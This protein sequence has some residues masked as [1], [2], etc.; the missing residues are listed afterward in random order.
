M[1][2]AL[3]EYKSKS[4]T[5]GKPVKAN[6]KSKVNSSN[7]NSKSIKTVNKKAAGSAAKSTKKVTINKTK[8]AISRKPI[9]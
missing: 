8:K 6:S 1:L 2:K 5:A 4:K 7:G 3:E 9:K